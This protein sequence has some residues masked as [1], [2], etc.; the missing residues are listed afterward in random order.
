MK[1][2]M[3]IVMI[4]VFFTWVGALGLAQAQSRHYEIADLNQASTTVEEKVAEYG[5]S[6]VLVVFDIDNTLLALNQNLGSDQWFSWQN[7]LLQA[8]KSKYLVANTFTELLQV[9]E[10]LYALSSSRLTQKNAAAIVSQL[11][12]RGVH[13]IALTAR[14]PEYRRATHRELLRHGLRFTDSAVGPQAGFAGAYRPYAI[15][16]IN[17]NGLSEREAS[18]WGLKESRPIR[19]EDGVLM[20][21]GQHK[22]AMLRTLLHKT[23]RSFS[24]IVF[25]DDKEKNT[26]S[27]TQGFDGLGVDLTT[28]RYTAEDENV[29]R[30]NNGPKTKA[31][32]SWQALSQ[33]LEVA[34]PVSE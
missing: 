9:Q 18:A 27:M 10:K 33:V 15:D 14:G 32:Q 19:Y 29:R 11:Q 8:G 20:V 17:E 23:N 24:A 34:F 22:G 31:I 7:E 21:A 4:G 2:S 12:R 16:R 25:I 1:I 13:V 3:K 26:S 6:Q 30:F 28:F 5:A